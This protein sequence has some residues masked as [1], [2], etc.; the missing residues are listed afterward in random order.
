MV[1][2]NLLAAM[3]VGII[4][5]SGCSSDAPVKQVDASV[6]D[7]VT[8]YVTDTGEKYHRADC[9]YLISS[10]P[11]TLSRAIKFGYTPCSRCN[12]PR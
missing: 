11:I 8:V 10:N 9:N 1:K 3:L 6:S 4:I 2:K 5:L 12:P 7:E